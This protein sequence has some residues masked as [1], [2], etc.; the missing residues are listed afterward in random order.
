MRDYGHRVHSDLSGHEDRE[1]TQ[2]AELRSW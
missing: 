1:T 2:E